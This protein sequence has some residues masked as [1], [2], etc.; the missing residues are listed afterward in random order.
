MA[1]KA[2]LFDYGN[3]LVRWDPRNLYTSI[4]PDPDER[5]HFLSVVCPMAW[6]AET[7]AG[8]PFADAVAERIAL[9][10]E[11]R[12][13]ILAW[14][15]RFGDMLGGEID[16]SIAI[17]DALAARKVPMAILTNMSAEKTGVCF[18]PFTR[19]DKIGPVIVSG[20]E[21]VAKPDPAIYRLALARMGL[22]AADVFFTDDSPRNVEAA[23]ALGMSGHVFRGPAGLRAALLSE[24]L[25]DG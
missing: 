6:H 7:D 5:A 18:A 1:A 20:A 17:V 9:F 3:V 14:D 8:R 15:A 12:A 11:H 24:G 16:G 19:M 23:L 2:V 13:A 4:I 25:L 10:P 22:A 21:K